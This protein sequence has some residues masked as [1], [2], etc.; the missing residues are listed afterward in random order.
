MPSDS[1]L[2]PRNA[3]TNIADHRE[4]D[5]LLGL[6]AKLQTSP[7]LE[8]IERKTASK[9]ARRIEAIRRIKPRRG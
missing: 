7:R 1:R 8:L 5:R 3:T 4:L 6:A 9:K 2:L